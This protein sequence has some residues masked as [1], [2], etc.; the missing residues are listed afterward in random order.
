MFSTLLFAFGVALALFFAVN[1]LA[2]KYIQHHYADAVNQHIYYNI[3]TIAS[4]VIAF[5]GFALVMWLYFYE[6]TKRITRL[7][8]EVTAVAEGDMTRTITAEGEDEITRLCTDVEYMR[9]SMLE[10]IEKE[11]L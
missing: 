1:I 3:S 6:I 11:S 2:D 4:I 8:K 10:N 7:A 5:I 9:S